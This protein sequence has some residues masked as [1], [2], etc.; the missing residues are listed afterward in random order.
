MVMLKKLLWTVLISMSLNLYAASTIDSSPDSSPEAAVVYANREVK[1][2]IAYFYKHVVQA[3]GSK[4]RKV[5]ISCD[6]YYRMRKLD[7]DSIG[8]DSLSGAPIVLGVHVS[9]VEYD[10]AGREFSKRT[11]DRLVSAYPFKKI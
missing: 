8:A 11:L 7:R 6:E 4:V 5:P 10:I 3:D 9:K 2:G 1:L